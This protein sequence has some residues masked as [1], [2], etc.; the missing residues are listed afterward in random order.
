ML[1]TGSGMTWEKKMSEQ[2]LTVNEITKKLKIGRTKFYAI[3]P[4]LMARGLKRIVIGHHV[5]FIESSLE[6]LLKKAA[7]TETPIV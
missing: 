2:Y 6:T 1:R 5:R 3:L 7:E 4:K